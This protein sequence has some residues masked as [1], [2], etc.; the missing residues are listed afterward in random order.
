MLKHG[1]VG[2]RAKRSHTAGWLSS[3]VLS[4]CGDYVHS[5]SPTDLQPHRSSKCLSRE[6][7]GF[8]IGFLICG[9]RSVFHSQ[10]QLEPRPIEHGGGC[11][12]LSVATDTTFLGGWRAPGWSPIVTDLKHQFFLVTHMLLVSPK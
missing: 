8:R 1:T 12:R 4:H 9:P 11:S 3:W 6:T 7:L 2:R 10:P 5:N